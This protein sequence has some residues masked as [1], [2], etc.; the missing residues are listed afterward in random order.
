VP[1]RSRNEFGKNVSRLRSDAGLTQEAL[2]EKADI[3]VRYL[4]FVEA[5]RYTPTVTV[6]ARIRN[7]LGCSWDELCRS[8]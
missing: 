3:S 4:Q 8:L 5:G 1:G 6:A 2:A 7:A